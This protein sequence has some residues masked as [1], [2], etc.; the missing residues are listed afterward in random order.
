MAIEADEKEALTMAT[1]DLADGVDQTISAYRAAI[2]SG[3]ITSAWLD[4]VLAA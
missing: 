1:T 3:T 4:K 2:A